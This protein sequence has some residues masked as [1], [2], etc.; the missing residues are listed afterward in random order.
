MRHAFSRVACSIKGI[1]SE[2]PVLELTTRRNSAPSGSVTVTTAPARGR[3]DAS[4]TTPS[5]RVRWSCA[6]SA[7]GTRKKAIA[8]QASTRDT[9]EPVTWSSCFRCA[10]GAS[11]LALGS[12]PRGLT[13][14][15]RDTE[16]TK[17]HGEA[18]CRPDPRRDEVAHVEPTTHG[19]EPLMTA[20]RLI[21]VRRRLHL[22]RPLRGRAGQA[23]VH[24]DPGSVRSPCLCA[25]VIDA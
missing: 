8:S 25:F 23:H 11:R 15:H 17:T 18:S 20:V 7:G 2:G 6:S 1:R 12:Q 16:D 9:V 4:T 5:S 3:P 24:R 13:A 22:R 14:G 19:N 10:P 21:P